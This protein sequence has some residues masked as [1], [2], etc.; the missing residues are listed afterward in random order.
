MKR[1]DNGPVIVGFQGTKCILKD[2][3]FQSSFVTWY[4]VFDNAHDQK[5]RFSLRM[6]SSTAQRLYWNWNS[7]YR[8]HMLKKDVYRRK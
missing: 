8:G 2:K 1:I 3:L 4:P 7:K 5:L 6:I